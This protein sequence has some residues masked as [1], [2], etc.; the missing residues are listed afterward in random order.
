MIIRPMVRALPALLVAGCLVAPAAAQLSTRHDGNVAPRKGPSSDVAATTLG[1]LARSEGWDPD[2]RQSPDGTPNMAAA[3]PR[4][5]PIPANSRNL[6]ASNAVPAALFSGNPE[7]AKRFY[8]TEFAKQGWQIDRE[9]N[10]RGYMAMVACKKKQ[11]VNLSTSTSDTDPDDHSSI[12][13]IFFKP[14]KVEIRG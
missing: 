4:D 13:L 1:D 7:T 5:F 2:F 9:I 12:R 10:V 11:C 8:R 3:I 14:G 6:Y